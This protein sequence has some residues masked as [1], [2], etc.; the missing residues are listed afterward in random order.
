MTKTR[1]TPTQKSVETAIKVVKNALK[2]NVSLTASSKEFGKGKNYVS[3][4]K[5]R[6]ASNLRKKNV[7]KETATTFKTLQKQYAKA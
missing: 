7:D 6:L 5:A 1:K 3:D 2:K 4:V